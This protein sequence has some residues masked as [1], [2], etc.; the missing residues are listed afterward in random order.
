MKILMA[1]MSLCIY[2]V[3]CVQTLFSVDFFRSS[4]VIYRDWNQNMSLHLFCT[5][6]CA[7][8]IVDLG[9]NPGSIHL[10]AVKIDGVYFQFNF[11]FT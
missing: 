10:S 9:S 1:V 11:W 2:S 7:M 6:K 5:T 4:E 8:M 3:L